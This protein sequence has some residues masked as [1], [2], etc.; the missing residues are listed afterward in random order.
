MDD[1]LGSLV[2]KLKLNKQPHLLSQISLYPISPS[3]TDAM[4]EVGR[5]L[6]NEIQFRGKQDACSPVQ[7]N[8]IWIY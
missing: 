8:S 4:W 6:E 5:S 7:I 2:S 3:K 1:I